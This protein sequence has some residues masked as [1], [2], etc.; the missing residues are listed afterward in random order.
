MLS[1]CGLG[2]KGIELPEPRPSGVILGKVLGGLYSGGNISVYTLDEVGLRKFIASADIQENGEFNLEF[3]SPTQPVLVEVRGG[4]YLDPGSNEMLTVEP[5]FIMSK[6]LMF[7]SGENHD[8]AI[9]PATHLL[10]GLTLYLKEN[11]AE[12]VDEAFIKAVEVKIDELYLLDSNNPDITLSQQEN[13]NEFVISGEEKHGLLILSLAQIAY[14]ERLKKDDALKGLFNLSSLNSLIYEDIRSDGVLDGKSLYENGSGVKTLAYGDQIIDFNFYR[15][16]I[17]LAMQKVLAK[18]S[19]TEL[20]PKTAQEEHILAVAQVES[21]LFEGANNDA[22][23]KIIPEISLESTVA[24]IKKDELNFDFKVENTLP[25]N[26]V[27]IEVDDLEFNYII[28]DIYNSMTNLYNIRLSTTSFKDGPHDLNIVVVDAFENVGKMNIP[29]TFDN[30]PPKLLIDSASLTND[31][32]FL[33]KGS[34]SDEFADVKKITINEQDATL[35]DN[36]RWQKAFSLVTGKNEFLIRIE[37][38]LGNSAEYN[39]EVFFDATA[40]DVIVT[41][42]DLTNKSDFLIEGTFNDEEFTTIRILVGGEEAEI[43]IPQRKWSKLVTL[44]GGPNDIDINFE[45]DAGNKSQFTTRVVFDNLSPSINLTSTAI[46]NMG[47]FTLAGEF[48]ETESGVKHILVNGDEAI[49]GSNNRWTKSVVLNDGDNEFVISIEDDAGNSSEITTKVVLYGITPVVTLTSESLTNTVIHNLQGEFVD[50]GFG[51]ESFTVNGESV[52]IGEKHKWSKLVSLN[53]GINNFVIEVQDEAGNHA[54][55]FTN[56]ILDSQLPT[57]EYQNN[58]E[59]DFSSNDGTSFLSPLELNNVVPIYFTSNHLRLS[60]MD[61]NK[62]NLVAEGIPYFAFNIGDQPLGEFGTKISELQIEYRY[63][64]N[65]EQSMDW[66]SVSLPEESS[67]LILPFVEEIYGKA[68]YQSIPT[69]EHKLELRVTDTAGN[70]KTE[71]ATFYAQFYVPKINISIESDLD[72]ISK[73]TF[74]NRENYIGQE[75]VAVNYTLDNSNNN[76]IFKIRINDDSLHSVTQEFEEVQREN[77]VK[78]QSVE[79]WR[80]ASIS[81]LDKPCPEIMNDWS[82]LTELW[83][84]NGSKWVKIVPKNTTGEVINVT[85]DVVTKEPLEW[86]N[87]QVVDTQMASTYS[88]VANVEISYDFDFLVNYNPDAPFSL[89]PSF[90]RDWHLIFKGEVTECANVNSVQTRTDYTY[91]PVEGF[92]RNNIVLKTNQE[93]F[94][95]ERFI[96]LDEAGSVLMSEDGWIDIPPNQNLTIVK[97]V[98][99]PALPVYTDNRVTD[100]ASISDYEVHQLDKKFDWKIGQNLILDVRF[101]PIDKLEGNDNI[102]KQVLESADKSINFTRN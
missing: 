24:E 70:I 20:N 65:D 82:T 31:S 17:A 90:I 84:R 44:V 69:D 53:E 1:A 91:L 3:V 26:I 98:N 62:D 25:L 58:L 7:N 57:I 18:T 94:N 23:H 75:V 5:D 28:D 99:T 37:D 15:L 79:S 9:T 29:V 64:L 88:K 12:P 102:R 52:T 68:W 4:R 56:V 59:V 66:Q 35:L 27:K 73:G 81:S 21:T 13:T 92:P 30:N 6:A 42:T 72:S 11:S 51:I 77:R 16:R 46:T 48:V 43:N 41:S 76:E 100:A 33:L 54:Q 19:F 60:G 47:Q 39:T 87:Y 89:D 45:D 96:V 34:H 40:P 67:E 36:N 61:P 83:N 55:V 38:T 95:S 2:G 49:I 50:G 32:N 10:A 97:Y 93:S 14:E 63:L 74:I 85:A 71:E 86:A 22:L 8:I 101:D 78:L 80:R